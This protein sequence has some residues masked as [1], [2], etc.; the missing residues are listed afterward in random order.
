MQR[1]GIFDHAEYQRCP[2]RPRVLTSS[3]MFHATTECA[4]QPAFTSIGD[5]MSLR[6][7]GELRA[8]VGRL[9]AAKSARGAEIGGICAAIQELWAEMC[10]EPADDVEA[11]VP[12]GGEVRLRRTHSHAPPLGHTAV[13]S[14]ARTARDTPQSQHP[15]CAA[16]GLGWSAAVVSTLTAKLTA[17]NEEKARREERIAGIGREITSLWKRLGTD[18]DAQTA[19]L[20]AHAGIGDDVIAACEEYL[21]GKRAEFA[22]RLVDLVAAARASI[23]AVWD[24][25]KVRAAARMK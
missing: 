25:M 12:L 21:A 8:E 4:P 17:L 22:A 1:E 7:I 9:S 6:R 23:S 11:A 14:P 2:S 3:I 18:E 20:E 16:Q 13:P 5:K 10:F 24:D 19:F 15:T